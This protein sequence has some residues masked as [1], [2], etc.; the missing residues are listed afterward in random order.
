MCANKSKPRY[1]CK[2]CNCELKPK[3][4]ICPNCGCGNRLVKMNLNGAIS[5]HGNLR[6]RKFSKDIGKWVKEIISGWF[7]SGNTYEHPKGVEKIRVID[8]ENPKDM[9]SYQEKITDIETGEI[10]RDVKEPLEE[11]RHK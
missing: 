10:I 6:G 2:N 11:H 5:F 4:K 7:Q 3:E 8:K 9:D 1:Y